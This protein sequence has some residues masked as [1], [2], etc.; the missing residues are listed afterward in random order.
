M[1]AAQRAGGRR[2]EPWE[3]VRDSKR[4]GVGL[5]VDQGTIRVEHEGERVP[6]KSPRLSQAEPRDQHQH[7][8]GPSERTGPSNVCVTT[9]KASQE[10][11]N[12]A[13]PHDASDHML[14]SHRKRPREPG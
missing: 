6:R 13:T 5:V 1:E 11:L 14:H 4:K 8:V 12:K 9:P 2:C 7:Q 10:M 3:W